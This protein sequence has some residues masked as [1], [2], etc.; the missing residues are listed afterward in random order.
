MV[1]ERAPSHPPKPQARLEISEQGLEQLSEEE[2]K[3]FLLL[4]P[5]HKRSAI[6][7]SAFEGLYDANMIAEDTRYVERMEDKF[8][9]DENPDTAHLKRRAELL[10][11][12]TWDEIG[13]DNWLGREAK[14]ITASRYDDVKNG[15][16]LI[17]EFFKKEKAD[18]LDSRMGLSVDVTSNVSSLEEKFQRIKNDIRNGRMA[19][20]KYFVS[21]QGARQEI[22]NVPKVVVGTDAVSIKELGLLRLEIHGL[23]RALKE[24]KKSGGLSPESIKSMET[25]LKDAVSKLAK[26]RVQLLF[27]GEIELQLKTFSDFAA[28]NNQPEIAREYE[29]AL[30]LIAEVKKDKTAPA[31]KQGLKL[32]F[33]E[34]AANNNDGVYQALKI[35]L[36]IFE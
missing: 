31:D 3:L 16:D 23:S 5:A 25:R 4:V 35:G 24:N 22:P 20:V 10:E 34:E 18:E 36:K 14:P 11:A 13:H 15:V 30:E 33:D 7:L 17:V 12:I 9:K 2:R 21:S 27:L 19:Y 29:K 6:H 1:T 8:R 28:K 26:H 32:S